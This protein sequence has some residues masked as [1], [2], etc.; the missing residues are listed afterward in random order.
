MPEIAFLCAIPNIPTYYDPL[1]HFD[2]TQS[3]K[4]RI[5]NQLLE[6]GRIEAAEYSDAVYENI[7]LKPAEAI[8]TQDYM[9]TYAISC[10][11]KEL[12]KKKG[13]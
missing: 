11:T 7:E 1:R 3:R 9:T 6:T 12:M 10:A 5:L 8:K 4:E 2:H 13:F